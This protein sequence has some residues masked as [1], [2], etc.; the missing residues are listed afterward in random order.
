[1]KVKVNLLQETQR[2]QQKLRRLGYLLQTGSVILLVVFGLLV[3]SLISYT[4]L[5]KSRQDKL[6][7]EISKVKDEID[8][9]KGKEY[10]NQ[11][12]MMKVGSVAE[13]VQ[14]H[15]L[16]CQSVIDFIDFA[17]EKIEIKEL[18]AAENSNKIMFSAETDSLSAF[19]GFIK[20]F[21]SVAEEL[22]IQNIT[23]D[24][25]DIDASGI[26]SFEMSL[27]LRSI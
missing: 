9:L 18:T 25:F 2:V 10:K 15:Q 24:G 14:E 4:L 8:A 21:I 19:V 23:N 17:R 6:T 22:G 12:F 3:I 1:M 16:N 13:V 27:T 20:E 11:L 26:L 7:T 5:L